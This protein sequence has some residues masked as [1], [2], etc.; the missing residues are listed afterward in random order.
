MPCDRAAQFSSFAALVGYEDAVK[1]TGRLTETKIELDEETKTVIDGRLQFLMANIDAE[2]EISLVY[3]VPDHK[4]SGGKYAKTNG[5]LTKIDTKKRLVILKDKTQ[6]PI[7]HIL[8]LDSP[9]FDRF[10]EE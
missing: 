8:E 10:S 1:E 6:I 5:I 2:P 4:K 9:L 3:F 7:E